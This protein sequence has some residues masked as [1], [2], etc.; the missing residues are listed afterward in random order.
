MLHNL[1]RSQGFSL[2]VCASMV[3]ATQ[4]WPVLSRA[5]DPSKIRYWQILNFL[6]GDLTG[7]YESRT[8]HE[9]CVPLNL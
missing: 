2:L 5:A 8:D 1:R 4:V 3:A 9:C 6:G 7:N